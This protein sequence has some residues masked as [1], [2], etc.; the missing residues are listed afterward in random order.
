MGHCKKINVS[1]FLKVRRI[2]HQ[3]HTKHTEN[4]VAMFSE[5]INVPDTF[6]WTLQKHYC[7]Q[8]HLKHRKFCHCPLEVLSSSWLVPRTSLSPFLKSNDLW[9]YGWNVTNILHNFIVNKHIF[10]NFENL[11]LYFSLL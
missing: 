6:Y 1:S 4:M 5:H 2:F 3:H 11:V 10:L 9:L 7:V 8:E